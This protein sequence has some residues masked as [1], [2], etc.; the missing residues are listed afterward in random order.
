MN[1]T[2]IDEILEAKWF[3]FDDAMQI[4]SFENTKELFEKVLFENYNF[5]I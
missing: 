4:I 1:E 3:D 5:S 2:S